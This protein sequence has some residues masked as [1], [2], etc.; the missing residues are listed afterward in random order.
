MLEL[1]VMSKIKDRIIID[2]NLWIS[3]L[4]SKDYVKLDKL[5]NSENLILLFSR[6]LLDEF[7]EVARRPKFKKYFSI[8]DLNELL[9][10]IHS[11]AEFIEVTS[12]VNLCRDEKDDFLLA[13]A[14][15]GNADFLVTGDNDLLELEK[16]E[17]TK[18]LTITNYL[19][20]K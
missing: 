1:S 16:F 15:D 7:V 4:L 6:E 9:T 11:R 8:S 2:T 18:I 19:E 17:K 14:K 20:Q 3:F 10:E 13:L 5:F 12:E